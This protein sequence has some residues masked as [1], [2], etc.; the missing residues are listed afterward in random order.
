MKPAALAVLVLLGMAT[1]SAYATNNYFFPGDAFFHTTLSEDTLN[2][3]EKEASPRFAYAYPN[4]DREEYLCGYAGFEILAFTAMPKAF[5]R[6]LSFV[7]HEIRKTH[8]KKL[9]ESKY[10]SNP[11]HVFFYNTTFDFQKRRLCLRYNEDWPKETQHLELFVT[12]PEAVLEEWRNSTKVKRLTAR[13]P[14]REKGF[15]SSS[16]GTIK[17]RKGIQ[18]VIL[19]TS[20]YKNYYERMKGAVIYVVTESGVKEYVGDGFQWKLKRR[21]RP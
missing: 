5:K 9:T 21:L 11:L 1:K 12:T 3:I 13:C 19:P 4:E 7:Y 15:H 6:N 16:E 20:D 8:S 14:A 10:E 17:V 2:R 18:A